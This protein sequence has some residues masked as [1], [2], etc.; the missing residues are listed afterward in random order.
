MNFIVNP[1]PAAA[2]VP[3]SV[4]D[5]LYEIID[6]QRVELL[7]MSVTATLVTTALT[8][9]LFSQTKASGRTAMEGLFHLALPVDRNRRPDIAFV[10]FDRWA[11][12]RPVGSENAWDVVPDAAIEVIS[13]S[14]MI[15]DLLV[16]LD[17][18]FRAGVRLACVVFPQQQLVYVYESFTQIRVL[19]RADTLE[20]GAVVPGFRLV[21]S[22]LFP[23][24]PS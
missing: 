1:A 20:G 11:K 17:E 14:D 15:E 21:L 9:H 18:Y 10:S 6:G 5:S 4:D 22:E 8:G 13:P 12:D 24:A 19:T 23:L 2:I 16:K 3:P 7:P